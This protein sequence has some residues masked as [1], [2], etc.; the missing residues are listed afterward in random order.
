MWDARHVARRIFAEAPGSE[1]GGGSPLGLRPWIR[2]RFMT[3]FFTIVWRAAGGPGSG[4]GPHGQP[5]RAY[6]CHTPSGPLPPKDP[7]RSGQGP[8]LRST[9]LSARKPARAT[10]TVKR[11]IHREVR[12]PARAP[13]WLRTIPK[14]KRRPELD[15]WHLLHP[16][17][18]AALIVSGVSGHD[19]KTCDKKKTRQD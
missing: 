17:S 8:R 9:S 2:P 14:P 16:R 5:Y 3:P 13:A 10:V 7:Y 4:R 6:P 19:A 18:P 1:R 12:M 11:N 15:P